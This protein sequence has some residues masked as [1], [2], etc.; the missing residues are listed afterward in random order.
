MSTKAIVTFILFIANASV[1]YLAIDA[2]QSRTLSSESSADALRLDLGIQNDYGTDGELISLLQSD[3]GIL[4]AS[5]E[6]VLKILTKRY[7]C[8]P[9]PW[10]IKARLQ[11]IPYVISSD[12]I[13]D[14]EDSLPIFV[15]LAAGA[16]IPVDISSD[17]TLT[18]LTKKLKKALDASGDYQQHKG[19]AFKFTLGGI[20]L[21]ATDPLS[22]QGISAQTVIEAEVDFEKN[23]A[24]EN[25]DSPSMTELFSEDLVKRMKRNYDHRMIK[26][27]NCR[28]SRLLVQSQ[29]TLVLLLVQISK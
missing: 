15:Q 10:L 1:H 6:N 7:D 17:A 18:D 22:E 25:D 4:N 26:K 3:D 29:S 19:K 14:D 23:Y 11:Q 28:G 5:N 21:N 8:C 16:E 24:E 27:I 20:E 2:D 13:A 9:T 12:L